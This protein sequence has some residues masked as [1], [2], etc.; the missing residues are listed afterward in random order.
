MSSAI[1][2]LIIPLFYPDD[3]PDQLDET[4]WCTTEIPAIQIWNMFVDSM[5]LTQMRIRHTTESRFHIE[6]IT[7]PAGSNYTW[8]A[9]ILSGLLLGVRL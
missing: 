6:D 3:H 4:Y 7:I 5:C 8:P 9:D 2:V 1:I